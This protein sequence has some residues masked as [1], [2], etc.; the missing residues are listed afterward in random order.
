MIKI[1]F[2]EN[3]VVLKYQTKKITFN[4]LDFPKST[5]NRQ[6]GPF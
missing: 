1:N 6:S 2:I 4:H 3:W 5:L